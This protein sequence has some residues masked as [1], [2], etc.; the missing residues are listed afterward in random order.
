M[1]RAK[2]PHDETRAEEEFV[3]TALQ[4]FEGLQPPLH[5][6][7]PDFRVVVGDRTL[8]IELTRFHHDKGA[9]GSTES[10]DHRLR[11]HVIRQ[12]P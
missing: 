8:G 3:Y 1:T 6:D 9:A 12:S 5:E 4:R 10:R 7:N 11:A 2:N